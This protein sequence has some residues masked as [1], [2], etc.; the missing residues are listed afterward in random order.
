MTTADLIVT[1]AR[2]LTMDEG[3]P[4]AEAIAVALAFLVVF[5]LLYDGI[6][7]LFG[8]KKHGDAIVSAGCTGEIT[9]DLAGVDHAS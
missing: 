2:V 5:W 8:H 9:S 3:A 7:R 6:C 1:N 4:R